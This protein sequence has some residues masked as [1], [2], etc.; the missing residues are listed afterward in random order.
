MWHVWGT[1]DVQT[2]F[3]WRNM[4]EKDHLEDLG[5]DVTNIKMYLQEV[6]QGSIDCIA[7]AQ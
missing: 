7:L 2:E 1:G 4:T 5:V 6:G 3:W